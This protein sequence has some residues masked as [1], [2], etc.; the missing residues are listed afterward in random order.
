MSGDV[1]MNLTVEAIYESVEAIDSYPPSQRQRA[2]A[3]DAGDDWPKGR[4]NQPH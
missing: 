1:Y 4:F 2:C 3:A